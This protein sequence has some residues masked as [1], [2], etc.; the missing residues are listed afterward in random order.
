MPD[1]HRPAPSAVRVNVNV[2][3]VDIDAVRVDIDAA[4]VNVN[5]VRGGAGIGRL[6]LRL[7]RAGSA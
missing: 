6:A 7:A 1:L 4:C 5:A 3:R 2:V